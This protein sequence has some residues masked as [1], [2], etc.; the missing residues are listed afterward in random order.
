[1][2]GSSIPALKSPKINIFSYFEECKS[3]KLL[4]VARWVFIMVLWGLWEQFIKYFLFRRFIAR[5]FEGISSLM[6]NM[7]P[8]LFES[9]SSLYGGLKPWIKKFAIG[10]LSSIIV[11]ETTKTSTLP[12]TCSER[13]SNL[14]RIELKFRWAKTN[15]FKLLQRND[16]NTLL[17]SVNSWSTFVL[18]DLYS[19]TIKPVLFLSRQ[20]KILDNSP[21]KVVLS[22]LE[23]LLFIWRLPL[24]KCCAL[25]L[26]V[27][28]IK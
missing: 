18:S 3:K 15:L 9:Q 11:S 6:Y 14:F 7:I 17:P 28:L 26:L 27:L 16:F 21:T 19:S 25:I 8:P 10:K 20:V 5:R 12:L 2:R 23:P 13:S 1:M 24:F 4:H 22:T